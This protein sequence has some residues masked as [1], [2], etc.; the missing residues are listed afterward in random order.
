VAWPGFHLQNTEMNLNFYI[1]NDW[2]EAN[3]GLAKPGFHW[4]EANGGQW[5]PIVAWLCQASIFKILK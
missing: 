1:L 4:P 2:P 3:R 5:R